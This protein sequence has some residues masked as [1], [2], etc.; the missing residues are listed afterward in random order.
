MSRHAGGGRTIFRAACRLERYRGGMSGGPGLWRQGRN[1]GMRVR[2]SPGFTH[3]GQERE[4]FPHSSMRA[5]GWYDHN[6]PA[7]RELSGYAWIRN[8]LS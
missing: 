5:N 6:V 8:T 7:G 4:W 2:G 1:G 3:D